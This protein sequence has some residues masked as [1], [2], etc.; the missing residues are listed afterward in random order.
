MP[1]SS[2]M[3]N[4][5]GVNVFICYH[6]IMFQNSKKYRLLLFV[7]LL[8][9]LNIFLF[10]LD[11][12][13]S[14]KGLT[15]VMLDVGQGEALFIESPTGTQIMF[16]GGGAKSVLGPLARA[17]SPFDKSI[18]A[19]VI[20]NPDADHIGGFVDILKNYTVGGVFEPGTINDSKL[21]QN[22]KDQ[23]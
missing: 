13:S 12:Q 14:N 4:V 18:D 11:F 23:I 10:R 3:L 8:L 19:L 7:F 21:Y 16:D 20:T 17:M 6:C 1:F 22:V 9:L 5:L 15:F 2:G